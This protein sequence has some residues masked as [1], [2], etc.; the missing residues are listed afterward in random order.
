VE[1]EE[2]DTIDGD[3]DEDDSYGEEANA[4]MISRD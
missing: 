4:D 1:E 2:S 3:L